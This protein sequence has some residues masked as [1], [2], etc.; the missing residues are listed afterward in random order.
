[1]KQETP[2]LHG[3]VSRSSCFDCQ[4][5]FFF[6]TANSGSS[7]SLTLSPAL[8]CLFHLLGCLLS[9]NIRT[10]S[11]SYCVL[12]SPVCLLSLE[13]VDLSEQEKDWGWI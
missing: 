6:E 12:F 5:I 7:V 11:L 13:G 8:G 10:F 3:S 1:M 2:T 9:L 4:Y